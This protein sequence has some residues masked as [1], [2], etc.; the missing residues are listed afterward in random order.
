MRDTHASR[1]S[2]DGYGASCS[3]A[4]ARNSAGGMPSRVTKLWIAWARALRGV[5]LS[6]R[7]TLARPRPSKSAALR[8]AGPPPT[9][10]T[11]YDFMVREYGVVAADRRAVGPQLGGREIFAV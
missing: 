3:R 4:V 2:T 11:S 8:P 7:R 10:T 1:T 9:M 5:P 6:A